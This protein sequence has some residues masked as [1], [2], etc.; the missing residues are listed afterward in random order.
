MQAQNH[1]VASP[2]TPHTMDPRSWLRDLTPYFLYNL[3]VATLGPLL[4]GFHLV[5]EPTWPQHDTNADRA[6]AN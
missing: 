4:F 5:S 2:R 1:A 3:F 6:R